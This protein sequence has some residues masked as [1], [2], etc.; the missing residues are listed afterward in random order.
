[1]DRSLLN[2]KDRLEHDALDVSIRRPKHWR[3]SHH[4]SSLWHFLIRSNHSCMLVLWDMNTK[5]S[6]LAGEIL[7]STFVLPMSQHP[8][9]VLRGYQSGLTCH[10]D[11]SSHTNFTPTQSYVPSWR[12]FLKESWEIDNEPHLSRL[13]QL[14][15]CST[16]RLKSFERVA[17]RANFFHIH[18]S[19]KH[20]EVG[21]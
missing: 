1:V 3:N 5:G 4:R 6:I 11:T 7:L 12:T 10:R 19:L 18:C 13:P 15:R 20:C 17:R 9:T 2:Y 8:N 14:K 21:C 16:L